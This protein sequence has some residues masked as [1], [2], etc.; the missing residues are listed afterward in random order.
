VSSTVHTGIAEAAG[1]PARRTASASLLFK[2]LLA[3]FFLLMLVIP[4]TF[5]IAR[6][7]LLAVLVTGAAY[8][9]LEGRWTVN[10]TIFMW[11]ALSVA[12]SLF[13]MWNGALHGAPGALAVSTVHVI[14]PFLYL[15]F[16]GICRDPRTIVPMEKVILLGILVASVMGIVLVIGTLTGT[17]QLPAVLMESQEGMAGAYDGFIRYRLPNQPTLIYGTGFLLALMAIPSARRWCTGR[18]TLLAWLTML[19]MLAAIML[20]GRRAAWLVVLVMPAIVFALLFV[21]RQPIRIVHWSVLA[22]FGLAVLVGVI[23]FFGLD[24][25]RLLLQFFN[26]FDF[27]AEQSAS[28][29][30]LQAEALLSGWADRPWLGHG[31]GAGD[32]SVRSSN[33]QPWAYELSYLALLY[34]TGLVGLF[35]Y[36]C[37]VL[38]IFWV[39][40]RLVRKMPEAGTV[41]LP[42]LAGL[43]GFL[44]ANGTNPYLAKFDYLW[45]I[46]LPVAALN[47][48]AFKMRR[49]RAK[50]E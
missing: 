39:G 28:A 15:L 27:S 36:G 41:M 21:S 37:A 19:L 22:G 5:Q 50:T 10:R 47:A 42:L 35:I 23:A 31:L 43:A 13:F 14:W 6:G 26:A 7:V 38:W 46:F 44:I 40:I 45:V 3:F 20:S 16:I 24:V 2:Q 1:G 9:A 11:C 8:A 18:W 34:Q 12:A 30:G 33:Q 48:Y 4:T 29:R 49:S 25:E 17:V 32:S